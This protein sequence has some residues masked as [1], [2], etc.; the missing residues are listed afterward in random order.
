MAYVYD[1][2]GRKKEI[3]DREEDREYEEVIVDKEAI[4]KSW[5]WNPD[6][7][8]M[9]KTIKRVIGKIVPSDNN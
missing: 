6:D 8:K 1:R 4:C 5:G 3:P 9:P 2:Y 7:V